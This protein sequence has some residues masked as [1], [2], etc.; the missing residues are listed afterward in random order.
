MWSAPARPINT[1][2]NEVHGFMKSSEG[3]AFAYE[4]AQLIEVTCQLRFPAILS[5]DT[6]PPAEFQETV[7]QAFPRYLCQEEKPRLPDGQVQTVRNHTFLT[8]DGV[9]K[10]NLTRDFIALSTMRYTCWEDFAHTLD[11]P[12]GQFISLYRPAYF[13]RVGLR[14]VNGISREKL[15]LTGRRWND[16]FQPQ[17]LGVLD[18]DGVEESAVSKCAVDVQMKLDEQAGVKIHAGPGTIKRAIMTAE[19]L[20]TAQEQ[21]TRFIFD[22]DLF[23]VGHTRIQGVTETLDM[24]HGHADRLFSEAI[25]DTL[26]EAMEAVEL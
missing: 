5:I 1:E 11:E 4:K 17:Y 6:N 14:Y 13:E 15:G 21:E 19:G 3:K 18:D 23:A 12:L 7:R 16:L 24:L 2:K 9:F 10:L 20:R 8:E 25:T 22:Q 26:H